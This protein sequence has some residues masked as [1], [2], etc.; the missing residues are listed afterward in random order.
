MHYRQL[1]TLF[2]LLSGIAACVRFTSPASPSEKSTS[3]GDRNTIVVDTA[4]LTAQYQ[5]D[6]AVALESYWAAGV[7]TGIKDAVLDLR[8]PQ[9]LLDVHFQ[10][11]LTLEQLEQAEAD[12]NDV[13]MVTAHDTLVQ[14]REKHTWMAS[15]ITP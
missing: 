8:V 5:H 13:L 14:L 3:V 9:E 12:D 15:P 10:L 2:F 6:V 7:T 11:V 1:I 4:N